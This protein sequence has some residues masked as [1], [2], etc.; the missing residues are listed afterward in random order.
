MRYSHWWDTYLEMIPEPPPLIF[1]P[2]PGDRSISLDLQAD[3]GGTVYALFSQRGEGGKPYYFC[4]NHM[5]LDLD[6]HAPVEVKIYVGVCDNHLVSTGTS[7]T[8]IARFSKQPAPTPLT[9]Q[10]P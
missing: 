6:G 10:H 9:H 1:H 4:S 2:R 8:V 7:G 5:A 3:D